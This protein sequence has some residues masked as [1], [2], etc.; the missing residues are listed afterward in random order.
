MENQPVSS[1]SQAVLRRVPFSTLWQFGGLSIGQLARQAITG[2]RKNQFDARSAQFAFYSM[3]A[4]APLLIVIIACVAQLPLEGVLDSFLKAVGV[5]MPQS[6]AQLIRRQVEDIQ[7]HS[8]LGL[9][10]GGLLLLAI[11]GSRVFLT[12]SAG[13]DTAY[14]VQQRRRFWKN[15]GV[16]LVLTLG[17]FVLFLV[18]MILLVLG[19]M[20]TAFITDRIEVAWVHVLLSRGVRWGVACGFILISASSIYWLCPTV[21]VPW[22]WLSP[23][24]T[25]AT[26]GWIVVTQGF[27]LYVENLGRYNE[28][29]GALGGVVVLLIW[30]Y[31]TGSLFLMGGQID[32]VIHRAARRNA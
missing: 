29:Y 2:Y 3:L 21:S 9:I 23:G 18:A 20:A 10:L 1:G 22:Y 17:V 28:T 15:G 30:L 32:S 25:F 13:L 16:A 5:G 11:A 7:A 14:N 24:S 6:V 26:T 8:S 12:L 19:P 4:L 27:R 31:L